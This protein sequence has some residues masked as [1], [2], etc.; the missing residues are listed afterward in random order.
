MAAPPFPNVYYHRKVADANAKSCWICYRPSVNVLITKDN[1]VL[2]RHEIF[3]A[4][5]Y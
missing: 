1:K 3:Y 2:D 4:M 5:H